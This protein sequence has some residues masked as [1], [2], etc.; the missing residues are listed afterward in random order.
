MPAANSTPK[1]SFF[2][3]SVVGDWPNMPSEELLGRLAGIVSHDRCFK[4]LLFGVLFAAGKL[5]PLAAG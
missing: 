1:R 5:A 4:Q 2:K 3:T